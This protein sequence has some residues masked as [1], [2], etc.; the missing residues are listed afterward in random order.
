MATVA[1]RREL[2]GVRR[3]VLPPPLD[4]WRR[5]LAIVA[6]LVLLSCAFFIYVAT[7][8]PRDGDREFYRTQLVNL[9]RQVRANG[10]DGQRP[11]S[12]VFIGTSRLKNV[13]FN[14]REVAQSARAAGVNRPVASIVLP[15]NWG[16]FERFEPTIDAI[17]DRRPDAVVIMPEL[18][19]EDFNNT[20]RAWLGFRFLQTKL[21][22]QDFKLFGNR[23]FHEPVCHG[24]ARTIEDR[25]ADHSE[26]IMDSRTSPGPELAR[27][28]VR[29]L[30]NVGALV[31]I[32][33]VPVSRR[34]LSLRPGISEVQFTSESGLSKLPNLR[35]AW[36]P[37]PIAD[38]EY[39]DWA[40]I[41]PTSANV[42]LRPFFASV[43][44]D[45][46]SLHR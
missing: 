36:T 4:L 18:F 45:L 35:T 6:V 26:W 17:V 38:E 39:C 13:A 42:W 46:N 21:W 43:A 2:A 20:S 11:L 7:P 34:M 14:A 1:L 9:D 28:T 8:L 22:G 16:G 27:E 33:D 30:A 25:L 31:I 3:A 32:G 12:I 37:G 44:F 24:F 40:H 5:T 29:R 23:E 15:I 10:A 41:K 19:F